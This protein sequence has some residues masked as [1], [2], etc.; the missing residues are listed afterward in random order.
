MPGPRRFT[1][2]DARSPASYF[3]A[4]PIH[5]HAYIRVR[6]HILLFIVG[7]VGAAHLNR[8]I[9]PVHPDLFCL[10]DAAAFK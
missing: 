1:C 10:V 6:K 3:A 2:Q 8:G 9:E 5:R 7:L 4:Y